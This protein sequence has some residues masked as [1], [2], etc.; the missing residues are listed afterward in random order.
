MGA[1]TV[2]HPLHDVMNAHRVLLQVKGTSIGK[3][4]IRCS[5]PERIDFKVVESRLR[6]SLRSTGP[7]C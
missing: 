7:I 2:L 4:V 3:G 6:D 5:R 1:M